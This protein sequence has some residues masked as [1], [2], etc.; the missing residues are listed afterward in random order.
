[1][2][3]KDVKV[4]QRVRIVNRSGLHRNATFQPSTLF[5]VGVV[6]RVESL[7]YWGKLTVQVKFGSNTDDVNW[8][9]HKDLELIEP[10]GINVWVRP[11]AENNIVNEAVRVLACTFNFISKLFKRK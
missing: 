9:N 11:K 2:E 3:L 6:S 1:M 4:G 7:D 10:L 5:R 8:G